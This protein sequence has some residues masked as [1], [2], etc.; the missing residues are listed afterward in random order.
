MLIFISGSHQDS[1]VAVLPFYHIYGLVIVLLHK[2]SVGCKVVTLP[3]FQPN[4]FLNTLQN[5]KVS[6]LYA[7]PPIG[8]ASYI[9]IFYFNIFKE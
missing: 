1:V 6:L 7:A 3:K 2:L 8:M 5:H 9:Y 4:T